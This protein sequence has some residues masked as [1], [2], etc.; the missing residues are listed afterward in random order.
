[1][2]AIDTSRRHTTNSN[3]V[4]QDSRQSIAG[5]ACQTNMHNRCWGPS[6]GGTAAARKGTAASASPDEIFQAS[7]TRQAVIALSTRK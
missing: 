7:N 3:S 4:S 5:P 2:S 6:C 1:M